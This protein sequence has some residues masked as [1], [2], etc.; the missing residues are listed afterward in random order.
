MAF[1]VRPVR[2]SVGRTEPFPALPLPVADVGSMF[3]SFFA[4]ANYHRR[5]LRLRSFAVAMEQLYSQSVNNVFHCGQFAVTLWTRFAR[6]RQ[7]LSGRDQ[8]GRNRR[9]PGRSCGRNN[10][11]ARRKEASR[12]TRTR[13]A[14]PDAGASPPRARLHG[15]VAPLSPVRHTSWACCGQ[16]DCDAETTSSKHRDP[17]A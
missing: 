15:Q 2:P 12:S 11:D 6:A 17:K 3:C 10:P 1:T 16:G 14:R 5:I 7:S 13:A 8:A 4:V 9:A